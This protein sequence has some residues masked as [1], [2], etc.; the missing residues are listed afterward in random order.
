MVSGSLGGGQ[1]C[2]DQAN[3]VAS[4]A[5]LP[6]FLSGCNELLVLAGSTYSTRLWYDAP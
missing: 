6:V 1:A 4:L 2:I 3:I 5:C